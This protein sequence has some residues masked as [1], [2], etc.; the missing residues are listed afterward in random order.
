MVGQATICRDS[1]SG[2]FVVERMGRANM[3]NLAG[4]WY[5]LYI[6]LE[7][8]SVFCSPRILIV[9]SNGREH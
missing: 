3:A 1:D 6:I 8:A 7:K 5:N 4:F 2:V 9:V